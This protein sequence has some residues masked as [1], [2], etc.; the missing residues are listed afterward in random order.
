MKYEVQIETLCDGWVNTWVIENED[1]TSELETFD[2]FLQAWEAVL[3][4]IAD[5]NDEIVCGQRAV[6]EGYSVDEFR[7]MPIKGCGE[8]IAPSVPAG[9][10]LMGK[11]G[12]FARRRPAV[13]WRVLRCWVR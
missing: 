5:I 1:G 2:S 13:L 4:F 11:Y 8:R 12:F 6:E 3:E 10:R 7:V 9:R